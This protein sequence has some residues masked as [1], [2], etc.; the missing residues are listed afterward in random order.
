[1]SKS[2]FLKDLT[3]DQVVWHETYNKVRRIQRRIYKA[4]ISGET[5]R[6]RWLQKLLITNPHA[7]MVAVHQVTTLNKGKGTPDL[8]QVKNLNSEQK[9]RLARNVS[10]NG[11]ASPIVL[12]LIPKPGKTQIRPMHIATVNDRAKQALAKLAL[13]P[14]WEAV[15]EPNSYGFRPGRCAQDA[16]ESIFLNLSKGTFKYVFGAS[17]RKSFDKIN[18]E[19]LLNK[20]HTF[21]L[22]RQQIAAWLDAGIMKQFATTP[23]MEIP[24]RGTA[25]EQVLSLLLCNIALHGLEQHLKQFVSQLHNSHYSSKVK[26]CKSKKQALSV[27]TYADNFV[28]IHK[29]K[30][31]LDLCITHTKTWLKQIGLEIWQEKFS[32]RCSGNGFQFLGFQIITYNKHNSIKVKIT[33][34]SESRK[35]LITKTHD[36]IQRHKASSAHTLIRKLRPVILGWGNYYKYVQSSKAFSLADNLI[37][38]QIRAWAMRRAVKQSRG[39]VT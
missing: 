34:S 8:D 25:Q 28:I 37:F 3:W 17:V 21:P 26:D 38:H 36:I 24:T 19:A 2:K 35:R 10:I 14:E 5:Y 1:M 33:P 6:V 4:K 7:K 39:A 23:P 11:K 22:M 15:F 9:I 27:I 16:V 20:L 30:T 29:D 32:L 12:K 18:H 31:I 13:E